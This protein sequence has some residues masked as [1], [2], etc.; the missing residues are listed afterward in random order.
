M[1]KHVF[2]R[3]IQQHFELI[4]HLYSPFPIQNNSHAQNDNTFMEIRNDCE[5]ET[6]QQTC[7]TIRN[8]CQIGNLFYAALKFN[9]HRNCACGDI[10]FNFHVARIRSQ[11]NLSSLAFSASVYSTTPLING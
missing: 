2:I 7:H 5:Y 11:Q 9:L 6:N 4:S 1:S 10:Y 8:F 3:V